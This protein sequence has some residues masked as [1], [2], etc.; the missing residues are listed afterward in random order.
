MMMPRLYLARN[1]LRQDGVIFISIDDNEVHNLRL[2][3]NEIFGEENYI[4][5]LSVENNPKGRKNSEFISVSH[6]YCLIFA[7][8]KE[9][10]KFIENIPKNANDMKKNENGVFVHQGGR[11]VIVGKNNFNSTIKDLN[12]EKHYSVY[13]CKNDDNIKIKKEVSLDDINHSLIS[14]GYCRYISFRDGEFVENTY[15]ASKLLNL[16]KSF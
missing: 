10:S 9:Q 11:R 3:C 6:D 1:L 15:T 14:K 13:Y 12:S 16:F 8:N 5:Q 4:G 7:K 2:L